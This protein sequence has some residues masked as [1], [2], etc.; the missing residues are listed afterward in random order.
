MKPD[1]RRVTVTD[2]I[3]NICS[4]TDLAKVC[5]H[6]NLEHAIQLQNKEQINVLVLWQ[7][8]ITT[9]YDLNVDVHL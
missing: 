8:Q 2:S 6:T 4:L 7:W 3:S 9:S 1:R 5:S